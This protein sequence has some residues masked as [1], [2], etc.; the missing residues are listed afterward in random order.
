MLPEAL[1]WLRAAASAGQIDA[2][3]E[4]GTLLLE[5]EIDQT[6]EAIK[7]LREAT[8]RGHHNARVMLTNLGISQGLHTGVTASLQGDL[9]SA[10][11]P[12]SLV[13]YDSKVGRY[14]YGINNRQ[15][16][17]RQNQDHY[18][19]VISGLNSKRVARRWVNSMKLP[20]PISMYITRSTGR[21][22]VST[23]IFQTEELAS[24]AAQSITELADDRRLT[25]RQRRLGD[26]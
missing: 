15:F 3:Y 5:K 6:E 10:Q 21:Y 23:G 26:I 24:Q 13:N 4:V 18:T 11:A 25:I 22:N 20:E 16:L 7:W 12:G 14:S 17:K 19:V 1:Y 2:Q 9:E 8:R